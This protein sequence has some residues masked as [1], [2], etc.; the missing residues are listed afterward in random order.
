VSASATLSINSAWASALTVAA[1]TA[2][3]HIGPSGDISGTTNVNSGTLRGTG[4]LAAVTVGNGVGTADSILAPGESGSIGTLKVSAL[5]LNS[6]AVF[7]LKLDT[8]TLA[9]DFV[10][11]SGQLTLAGS[12][13]LSLS[14]IDPSGL[15]L[16]IGMQIP[17]IEYGSFG[18][19]Q[20]SDAN[21]N[22]L[23]EGADFAFGPNEFQISYDG[24]ASNNE[25]VLT[26]VTPEPSAFIA[27]VCGGAVLV[28]GGR[29]RRRSL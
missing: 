22:V 19:G 5:T 16:A 18:G 10:N 8:T 7:S 20:F 13:R 24:G 29:F 25:V 15:P 23:A 26:A 3:L 6:D 28:G 1:A 12:P 17:F 4:T 2:T 9:N 27:L 11:V 14:D 21:G